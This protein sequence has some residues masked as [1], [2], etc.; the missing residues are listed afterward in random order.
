LAN[1]HGVP[2]AVV[3]MSRAKRPKKAAPDPDGWST[4]SLLTET[5]LGKSLLSLGLEQFDL[6]DA[7]TGGLSYWWRSTGKDP[8]QWELR[9]NWLE[10]E[11][12][13]LI[14]RERF[15][16]G[17]RWEKNRL[18][19]ATELNP[20][21]SPGKPLIGQ[22]QSSVEFQ[23]QVGTTRLAVS[24]GTTEDLLQETQTVLRRLTAE[25]ALNHKGVFQVTYETNSTPSPTPAIPDQRILL[26]LRQEVAADRRIDLQ[27][28][29]RQWDR[30][31][32]D[33]LTWRLDLLAAF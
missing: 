7:A 4:F 20:E 33:D 30:K 32:N 21:P 6:A 2:L 11:G 14:P 26:A 25:A 23:T 28:E 9:R 27:A 24:Y 22:R 31:I 15:A 19:L 3:P 10:L 12:G 17:Y 29:L 13:R 18:A 1:A 5:T 8:L 16:L